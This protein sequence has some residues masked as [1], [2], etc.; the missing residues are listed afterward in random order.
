MAQTLIINGVTYQNVPYTR[1]PIVNSPDPTDPTDYGWYY[2]VSDATL[3]NGSKMLSGVTG[4]GA[5]G[6]KYTGSILTKTASDLSASGATVTV[7]AGYYASQ[8]TKSVGNGSATVGNIISTN[9]ATVTVSSGIVTLESYEQVTPIVSPGY[10]SSGTQ[11]NIGVQLVG[12]MTTK[13]AATYTPG[14]SSQTIAANQYLLGAQTIQGD[15]NLSAGNIKQ[16]VSIFGIAGTLASVAVSQDP[17]TKGLT[18][19]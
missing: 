8:Y 3:D 6:V 2:D 5:N 7:P 10:I 14:T 19:S 9:Q 17:D 12:L 16:G 11:S 15:A 13:A 18:I 1:A 4:Y